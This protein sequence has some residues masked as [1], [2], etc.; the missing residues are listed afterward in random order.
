MTESKDIIKAF[1]MHLLDSRNCELCLYGP[2]EYKCEMKLLNDVL[3]LV[4]KQQAENEE[5]KAELD[6]YKNWY[7]KAV[8]DLKIAKTEAYKEFAELVKTEIKEKLDGTDRV[9]S[10]IANCTDM[11]VNEKAELIKGNKGIKSGLKYLEMYVNKV[12][13]KLTERKED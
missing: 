10:E 4:K 13:T 9:I 7:L 6:C 11:L 12:L 5:L 3:N 8:E 2:A 1:E